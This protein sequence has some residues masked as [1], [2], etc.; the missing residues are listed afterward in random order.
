MSPYALF[1][2]ADRAKKLLTLFSYTLQGY[3][4]RYMY[5]CFYNYIVSNY[6]KIII[7]INVILRLYIFLKL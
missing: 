5:D 4:V 7:I 3:I 1:V 6:N 2:H